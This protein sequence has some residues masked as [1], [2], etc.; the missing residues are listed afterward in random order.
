M[1]ERREA[2]R[3]ERIQLERLRGTY[4]NLEAA[5]EALRAEAAGLSK[6]IDWGDGDTPARR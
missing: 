6:P 2:E 4:P 1:R 5:L 3:L